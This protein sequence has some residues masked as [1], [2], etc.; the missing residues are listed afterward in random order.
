VPA[1]LAR[2]SALLRDGRVLGVVQFGGERGA[3]PLDGLPHVLLNQPVVYA[4]PV[5]AERVHAELVHAEIRAAEPV[6]LEVWSGAADADALTVPT[7]GAG[8]VSCRHNGE[9]IFGA[10]AVPVAPIGDDA[11][12]VAAY[13]AYR[14]MLDCLQA[15]RYPYLLRIWN[16]I[17]DINVDDAGLD[18]YRRFN[19]QRFRAYAEARLP[20][21]AGA[22]AASALGTFGGS[23]ALHFLAARQSAIAIE[24]PRQVSAY[25]YPDQ[26]G[27]RAPS[28]SRA[29]LWQGATAA[30]D[31]LFVS[32]TASI[33]G[34]ETRHR[35]DAV[36]Q[37]HETV[38][39]VKA[40]LAQARA[41]VRGEPKPDLSLGDLALKTYVRHRA[42]LPAVRC[43]LAAAGVAVDR[44]LFLQADICRADL[45]LEIEAVGPAA[46]MRCAASEAGEALTSVSTSGAMQ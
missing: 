11:L 10:I 20:T 39:N 2:D 31:I 23:L 5:H 40:V 25:D 24:N 4:E 8:P 43:A 3:A 9:L 14:A 33:V 42:H 32:G 17:P 7:A 18:R 29:A 1:A 30:E 13:A 38:A 19:L 22:P 28:F 45:L 35:G 12:G 41:R 16:S 34:H 36:A 15:A 44:V 26:Y 37:T 21:H 6:M 46:S 27:P